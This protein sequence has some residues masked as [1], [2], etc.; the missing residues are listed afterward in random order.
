MSPVPR[1]DTCST[2][3]E[4][5]TR[6]DK[7]LCGPAGSPFTVE[8]LVLSPLCPPPAVSGHTHH[9]LQ[10][11]RVFDTSLFLLLLC[12]L[13]SK[14]PKEGRPLGMQMVCGECGKQREEKAEQP[15]GVCCPAALPTEEWL[16][17]QV[18]CGHSLKISQKLLSLIDEKYLP[19]L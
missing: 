2:L 17:L 13:F 18:E 3:G 12:W 11:T 10:T 15:G 19:I 5:S 16:F 9:N 7:V 1:E 8:S 4:D 14:P 6:I